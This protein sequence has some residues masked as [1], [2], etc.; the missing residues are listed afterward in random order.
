MRGIFLEKFREEVVEI[1]SL[2]KYDGRFAVCGEQQ[3]I[4]PAI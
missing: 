1:A 3:K 2:I 4:N